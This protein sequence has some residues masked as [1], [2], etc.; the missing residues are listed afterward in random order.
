MVRVPLVMRV[1]ARYWREHGFHPIVWN[2]YASLSEGAEMLF[3]FAFAFGRHSAA[4]MVH[5]AFLLALAWQFRG[6][7]V[8]SLVL[9]VMLLLL[10]LVAR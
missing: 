3:L 10:G 7:C 8:R 4:S 2:L 1:V 6:D 9:S 5:F